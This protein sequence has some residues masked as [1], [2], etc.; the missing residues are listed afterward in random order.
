M[1]LPFVAAECEF[2]LDD[3]HHFESL[4]LFP[5]YILFPPLPASTP[6]PPFPKLLPGP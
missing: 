3:Q 1:L 6:P 5:A 2:I 4:H